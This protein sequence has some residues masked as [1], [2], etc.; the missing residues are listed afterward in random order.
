MKNEN[1][2]TLMEE[3]KYKYIKLKVA[4]L[5]SLM[6]Y[7]QEEDDTHIIRFYMSIT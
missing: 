2:Q 5:C 1:L 3:N 4:Y 7:L 6:F